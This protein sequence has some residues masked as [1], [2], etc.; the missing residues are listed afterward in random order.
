MN[1]G[2]RIS[3]AQHAAMN[4]AAW[5][6]IAVERRAWL[7]SIGLDAPFFAAGGSMLS[8]TELEA[9]GDLRGKRVLHLQCATGEDTL[10]LANQGAIVTGIDVSAR[11]I[12][13]AR[14]KATAAGISATFDVAD[15]QALPDRYRRGA[16]DIV[17]TGLG[18][19]LWLDNL[20]GWGSGIAAALR[21][22]GTFVLYEAHPIEYIYEE[23]GGRLVVVHSYFDT[24]PEYETGWGHFPTEEGRATKAEFSWTV[25]GVVSALGR[26][27][28]ATVE[29]REL[30]DW[31]CSPDGASRYRFER[32]PGLIEGDRGK[33]PAAILLRAVKV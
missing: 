27:G 2:S 22:G 26:H 31:D 3:S 30:P 10:S 23:I 15:V 7:D 20:D 29:L 8:A 21:P 1:D 9:L 24:E 6:E 13:E 14:A 17:Y 32:F 16:F 18:A 19:I 25:G 28:V 11:G 12:D 5:D 4:A 33:V